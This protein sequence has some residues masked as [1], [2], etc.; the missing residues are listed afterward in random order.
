MVQ[1]YSFRQIGE[2]SPYMN[3]LVISH[4]VEGQ[5]ESF[6]SF[7]DFDIIAFDWYDIN[8]SGA[9]APQIIIYLDADNLL[10]FC[11]DNR[12][13][14]KVK[15][16]LR[17][18]TDKRELDNQLLLYRFFVRL[19]KDDMKHLDSTEAEMTEAENEM[20][21]QADEDYLDR[22]IDFRHELLDLKRYY[23]QLSSIFDE[24]SANDNGRLTKESVQRFEIL[25]NRVERF[26]SV[27]LNLQEYVSQMRE[28]YQSQIDIEQNELMKLFTVVTV[29]FQP[30]TLLVGWYGMNFSGMPELAWKYGYPVFII[31]S[32]V[33]VL[34]LILYFKKKK[35]F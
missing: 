13:R 26:R 5:I 1:V 32:A 29:I 14:Q 24:L 34:I 15:E 2:A 11:E 20:L 33:I 27:T 9:K 17:I 30:L 8:H 6:E 7:P 12:A 25:S 16:I 18:E 23:E 4:I 31:V 22:I 3:A 35:W 19:L 10:F 28:A 21:I